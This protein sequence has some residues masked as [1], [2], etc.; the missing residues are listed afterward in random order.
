MQT[1]LGMLAIQ[2]FGDMKEQA[3]DTMIRDKFI[4]GQEQC[5]L[6]RQLDGFGWICGQ[7]SCVGES[8]RLKQ[9]AYGK[10]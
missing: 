6:R 2:G 8:F 9:D 1:D 4:A 7:L 5:A 10:L 3:G